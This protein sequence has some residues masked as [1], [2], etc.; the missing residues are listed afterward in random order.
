MRNRIY[1]LYVSLAFGAS[2]GCSHAPLAKD[3]NEANSNNIY[4]QTV[5]PQAGKDEGALATLDGE[6]SEGV[7]ERY[8]SESGKASSD[9]ILTNM[10]R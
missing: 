4:V 7:L 8:R 2:C 1:W 9:T 5:N 3:F 6:K 10:K